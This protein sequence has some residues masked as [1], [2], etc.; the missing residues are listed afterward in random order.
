MY[1]P[2]DTT[3]QPYPAHELLRPAPP[4][5]WRERLD[6]IVATGSPSWRVPLAAGLVAVVAVLGWRMMAP[7]PPPPEVEIPLAQQSA[8]GPDGA[9]AAPGEG[10]SGAAAPAADPAGALTGGGAQDGTLAADGTGGGTAGG[11]VVVHVAGAVVMPG[12]QRLPAGARVVDAVDASGGAAPDA[13]L[14]RINLAAVLADGQQ[15]YVVRQ[16]ELP[17]VPA[18]WPAGPVAGAGESGDPS[19][20]GGPVDINTASAIQLE[21]LPGVGPATAAAIVAHREQNGPFSSVDDLLDVRGIGE[22]KLD[23]LRDLATV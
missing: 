7:P 2:P 5:T 16:G 11:E 17:P 13:D 14:G 20:G 18:P 22:A 9:A 8:T 15:V 23:A 12:V 10:V 1:A 3:D 21:E 19:G 4:R 6:D